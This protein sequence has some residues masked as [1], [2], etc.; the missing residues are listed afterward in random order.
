MAK[1]L[2]KEFTEILNKCDMYDLSNE[3]LLIL[4]EHNFWNEADEWDKK[5][6]EFMYNKTVE[7]A[8]T[9]HEFLRTK[10]TYNNL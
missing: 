6:N 5:G 2:K 7:K 1:I 9:I 10:G 3:R 4:I 8:K